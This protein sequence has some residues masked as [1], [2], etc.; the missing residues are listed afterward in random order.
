MQTLLGSHYD[1]GRSR[2]DAE[3]RMPLLVRSRIVDDMSTTTRRTTANA[4]T[5]HAEHDNAKDDRK[6]AH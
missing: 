4:R 5:E 6:R 1:D 2:G 3:G